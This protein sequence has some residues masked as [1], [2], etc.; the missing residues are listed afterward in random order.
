[1]GKQAEGTR[2][3]R[4]QYPNDI[5]LDGT[6]MGCEGVRWMEVVVDRVQFDPCY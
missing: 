2:V 4:V 1:M 5:N 6:I 3:E